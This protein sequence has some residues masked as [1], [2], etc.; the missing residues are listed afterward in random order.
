[1]PTITIVSQ[2]TL[3][4]HFPFLALGEALVGRGHTIRYLG[5]SHLAAA[6]AECGMEAWPFR[7][8]VNPE[9]VRANPASYDHWSTERGGVG[10][11]TAAESAD[12][13][14]RGRYAEKLEDALAAV[15]G[16]DLLLCSRLLPIGQ[17]VSEL[18]GVPWITACVV[19][20]FYPS[21]DTAAAKGIEAR[22]EAENLR[23]VMRAFA[24]KLNGWRKNHGL[25]ALAITRARD[26]FEASRI[27]LA[28][29]PLFG[30]PSMGP[31]REIVQTGFWLHTPPGW[32]K[33]DL[34]PEMVS[35]LDGGDEPP[36]VLSF[37]S[38]PVRDASGFLDLHLKAARLLG[39]RLVV[40]GGWAEW[41]SPEF[42]RA[43]VEGWAMRLPA[44]PQ[45][46]LFQRAGVVI[47]HGGI[48]TTA[49]AMLA[50][51]PQL[52]E[53]HGNDQFYNARQVMALGAGAA[54]N[55]HRLTAEGLASVLRRE[56]FTQQRKTTVQNLAEV[57]A[58]EPGVADAIRQLERWLEEA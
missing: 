47:H 8:D 39:R 25:D 35:W 33:Q 38:Q 43:R 31:G 34:A 14:S 6:I 19:P 42:A 18:T 52:V 20:W 12:L 11:K 21:P 56:V 26:F 29:S 1:M 2:G 7:C 5:P 13:F 36:M 23:P 58:S 24:E 22:E 50:A 17:T 16:S 57:L 15:S 46:A 30:T 45:D 4:D 3:G 32:R 49:R 53:P 10:P 54:V 48:G 51:A 28:T 27:L 40:Q 41:E 55:P 9:H 44:G 37:S